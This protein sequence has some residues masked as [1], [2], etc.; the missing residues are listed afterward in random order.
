MGVGGGNLLQEYITIF[1]TNRCV[2]GVC[3]NFM[4]MV[5]LRERGLETP[6]FETCSG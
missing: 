4:L 6:S 3:S 5:H 1:K 2:R